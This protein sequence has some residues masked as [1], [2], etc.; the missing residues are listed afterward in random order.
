MTKSWIVGSLALAGVL[1]TSMPADAQRRKVATKAPKSGAETGLLGV[2]LFDSGVRVIQIYGNPDS[3]EAVGV[4][5]GNSTPGGGGGGGRGGFGGPGGPAGGGGGGGAPSLDFTGPGDF[6]GVSDLPE[7]DRL[8]QTPPRPPGKPGGAGG[9]GG[10]AG[11]GGPGGPAGPGG[12]GG[13]PGR[14]GG[15]GGGTTTE[16]ADYIRWVYKKNGARFG[17]I[18]DK[19]DRVVQIEAIGLQNQRVRTKRGISFG[20]TFATVIKA[21]APSSPPDSYVVSGDTV[22]VK[23]ITRQRVAFRLSKLTAKAPHVVTGIVV[24]AGKG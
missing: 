3:I 6:G 7:V 19:F 10:P 1:L 9:P 16:T 23:F 21:Y 8:A 4:A 18:M 20:S 13:A 5:A 2:R 11:P 24:A 17:F 12:P 22:T 15:P 14:D